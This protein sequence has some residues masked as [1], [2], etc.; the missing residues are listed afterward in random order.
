MDGELA[1]EVDSAVVLQAASSIPLSEAALRKALGTLG[2]NSLS[3]QS[4]DLSQLDLSAG[5]SIDHLLPC[6]HA[7]GLAYCTGNFF[8]MVW[9]DVCH[10]LLQ[11]FCRSLKHIMHWPC[12]H[13][14]H[15]VEG[16]THAALQLGDSP[17]KHR[18]AASLRGLP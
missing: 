11:P 1:A 7:K 15:Y 13:A 12:S 10:A 18:K 8:Y 5:K 14:L 17:C 9:P 4:L 3:L 6:L 2:S 16:S